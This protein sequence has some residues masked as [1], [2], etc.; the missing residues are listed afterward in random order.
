LRI[1]IVGV[2]TRAIAE[3][4]TQNGGEIITLDYFGDSD[5][6]EQVTNYSLKRDFRQ[7]FSVSGLGRAACRLEAGAVV[8]L[9]NLEN[10]PN[11]VKKIAWGRVLLGN[12]PRV[13][14][15]ARSWQILQTICREAGLACP[16]TLL[17]GQEHQ[18]TTLAG[19]WLQKPVRSGC[20]HGVRFWN[21]QPLARSHLLQAFVAGQPASAVFVANGRQSVLLGMSE[22]LIGQAALGAPGFTWCGNILPL[23]GSAALLPAVAHMA[24][25]L[26]R[27]L[28]LRGVNG[29]DFIVA[30]GP[31]GRPQPWLVEINPRY[32]ASMELVERAYGINI[33]ALHLA[34][35]AG[36]LPDFDLAARLNQLPEV[37]GKGIVYARQPV[38]VPDTAGWAAQ[39]RRDIPF[40]GER[41]EA[42]QPVCT[43]LAL[44][45][46]RA[47]C[48]AGL[49][50]NAGRVRQEIGDI[51]EETELK[52]EIKG[53]GLISN[54]PI[55]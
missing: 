43:V 37:W 41:V 4:A 34:A 51:C 3:S 52:L 24:A 7:P 6:R 23:V 8:Y 28:D 33:F 25:Q 18:A 45:A 10:Y 31:N 55:P 40:P 36:H 49:L 17:P 44:A 11:L 12:S 54:L 30:P 32:T 48:W 47:E 14:R 9:S 29:L 19:R 50:A 42:G 1:L 21:G 35:M 16:R 22:Q 13:L 2:S 15:Q 53:L 39:N 27:R 5:Q 20:G 38:T 46:S 26:T